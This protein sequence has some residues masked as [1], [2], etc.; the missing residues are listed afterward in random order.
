MVGDLENNELGGL[1]LLQISHQFKYFVAEDFLVMAAFSLSSAEIETLPHIST[2]YQRY[3]LV[4]S[5]F[6]YARKRWA[7]EEN[8]RHQVFQGRQMCLNRF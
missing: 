5:A 1:N 8:L 2:E 3:V 4:R 6:E 7:G